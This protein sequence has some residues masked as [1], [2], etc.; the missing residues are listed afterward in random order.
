MAAPSQTT[1]GLCDARR[2]DHRIRHALG[3]GRLREVLLNELQLSVAIVLS[4]EEVVP[5]FRVICPEGDWTVFG[6]WK[7]PNFRE[8]GGRLLAYLWAE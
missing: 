7:P 3:G 8:V 2:M 6:A 4:R 5:R 1:A